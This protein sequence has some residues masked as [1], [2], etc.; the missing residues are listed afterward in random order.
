MASNLEIVEV[1][2]LGQPDQL[3]TGPELYKVCDLARSYCVKRPRPSDEINILANFLTYCGSRSILGSP[4]EGANS[5]MIA[6]IEKIL[7]EEA[8]YQ[9]ERN[10]VHL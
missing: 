1:V 7:V 5:T 2:A 9:T 4:Q 8:D 6:M 3:L 10:S